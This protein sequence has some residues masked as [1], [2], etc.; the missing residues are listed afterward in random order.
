MPDEISRLCSGNTPYLFFVH[1]TAMLYFMN[2]NI[3][4]T[5][6]YN[7]FSIEVVSKSWHLMV[8]QTVFF[9]GKMRGGGRRPKLSFCVIL[10]FCC[11]WI[12]KVKQ[13]SEIVLESKRERERY[14][15]YKILIIIF[16][17]IMIY[18]IYII[19]IIFF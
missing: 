4:I 8:F 15:I 5:I 9:G 13:W 11:S 18:N 16:I 19:Y 2:R 6:P 1:D 10:T 7:L 17:I 14:N 12:S 3:F